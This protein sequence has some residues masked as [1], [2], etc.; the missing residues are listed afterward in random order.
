[1]QQRA[2]VSHLGGV[3]VA[4]ERPGPRDVHVENGAHPAGPGGQH[5][6]PVG[7][8]DRLLDG[9]GDE[10]DRGAE[11]HVDALQLD[12]RALHGSARRARRTARPSAAPGAAGSAP[13]TARPAAAC[14]RTARAAAGWRTPA[15][16]TMLQQLMGP[17]A[18]AGPDPAEELH[19]QQ[20][21]AQH[22]A[23]RQQSRALEHHR[24]VPPRPADRL[25]ADPRLPAVGVSSPAIRRSRVDLP[26]PERPITATNS[27]SL[28]CRSM[29]R[30]ASTVPV[31]ALEGLRD[32]GQLDHV[33][34]A[35]GPGR[36]PRPGQVRPGRGRAA[37]WAWCS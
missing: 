25:R 23:P 12:R 2:V 6:D 19:R 20:H 35:S 9:V 8:Q 18:V 24:D 26:Q 30:N 36:A 10:D 3:R 16:P 13:G 17:V 21:I 34:G 15:S 29:S 37:A 4:P 7:E 27:P 1:M 33:R 5:R 14:R 31:R 28:T 22:R 32:A 11:L